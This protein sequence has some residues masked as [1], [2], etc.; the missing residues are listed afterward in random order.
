MQGYIHFSAQGYHNQKIEQDK[1][2]ESKIPYKVMVRYKKV[3]VYKN[4]QP[5]Y[6]AVDFVSLFAAVFWKD[7]DAYHDV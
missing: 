6:P 3:Y 1:P 7:A 2:R 5:V 4:A